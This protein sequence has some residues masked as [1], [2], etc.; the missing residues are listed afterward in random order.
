MHPKSLQ[1]HVWYVGYAFSVRTNVICERFL[2]F[3]IVACLGS[4]EVSWTWWKHRQYALEKV[5]SAVAEG[6]GLLFL[7]QLMWCA[8][9][10]AF[11]LGLGYI[12]SFMAITGEGVYHHGMKKMIPG[13]VI[14]RNLSF[15]SE[16]PHL[17]PSY[18]AYLPSC[19][20]SLSGLLRANPP[21][22]TFS[23]MMNPSINANI[24]RSVAC[25]W[26]IEWFLVTG[27]DTHWCM[28]GNL[29]SISMVCIHGL[30]F[31]N[32]HKRLQARP[33]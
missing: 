26:Q 6:P 3:L 24:L 18:K 32:T 14:L 8:W 13:P 12:R 5:N 22:I 30:W 20:H 1:H 2:V 33:L 9:F 15:P 31:G 25:S 23:S 7:F 27:L 19:Q 11:G 29:F 4:V 28:A 17:C 21:R 10:E 16:W